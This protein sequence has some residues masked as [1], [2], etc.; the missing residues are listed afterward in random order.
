MTG[1]RRRRQLISVPADRSAG[2]L[3]FP[4]P[5]SAAPV[6]EGPAGTLVDSFLLRHHGRVSTRS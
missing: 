4:V 5:V 6:D 3:R 2:T 1:G